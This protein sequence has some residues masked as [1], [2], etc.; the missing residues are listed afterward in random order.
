MVIEMHVM[1][2]K[3]ATIQ[4]VV[5]EITYVFKIRSLFDVLVPDSRQLLDDIRYFPAGIDGY[6][7]FLNYFAVLK[8][9]TPELNDPISSLEAG[10]RCLKIDNG[11]GFLH[12]NN[13][14]NKQKHLLFRY[15]F[16]QDFP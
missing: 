8:Q 10:S 14:L 5:D 16:P 9:G 15:F 1:R 12:K 11:I 13:L 4:C 7:D 2:Y 3:N 6:I